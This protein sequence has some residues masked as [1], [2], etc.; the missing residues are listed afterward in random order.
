[1]NDKFSII[2]TVMTAIIVI[3]FELIKNGVL[4]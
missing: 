4:K 3:L 1:M 2:A